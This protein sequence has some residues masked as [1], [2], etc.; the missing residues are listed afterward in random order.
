MLEAYTNAVMPHVQRLQITAMSTTMLLMDVHGT[1]RSA[2]ENISWCV[3]AITSENWSLL[4]CGARLLVSDILMEG[5]AFLLKG[6]GIVL[7]SRDP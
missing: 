1:S 4:E 2:I 6:P 7:G 3:E 5:T